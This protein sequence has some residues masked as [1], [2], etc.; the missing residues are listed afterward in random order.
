MARNVT[1]IFQNEH[2]HDLT[3]DTIDTM[4]YGQF[5]QH[6]FVSSYQVQCCF[7]LQGFQLLQIRYK[8]VASITT[9][10]AILYNYNY[11]LFDLDEICI[12]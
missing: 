7:V 12:K 2:E 9:A 10:T 11:C 1:F 6:F 5:V 4:Q 3:D 8:I